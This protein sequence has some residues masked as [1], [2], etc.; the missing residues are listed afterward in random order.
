MDAAILFLGSGNRVFT[1]YDALLRYMK[2]TDILICPI[3]LSGIDFSGI[4]AL[5]GLRSSENF[6]YSSDVLNTALLHDSYCHRACFRMTQLSSLASIEDV[7][8]TTMFF[9]S[10]YVLPGRKLHGPICP[11][12]TSPFGGDNFLGAPRHKDGMCVNFV[13]G[14]LKWFPR[15]GKILGTCFGDVPT[16]TLPCDLSGILDGTPNT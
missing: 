9:D 15:R 10:T 12:P 13:D 5:L 11:N 7:V 4:M 2:N 16:Y 3:N 6:R 1:V 8:N 14:H